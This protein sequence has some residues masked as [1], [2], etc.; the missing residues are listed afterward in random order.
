MSPFQE[1]A[2]GAEIAVDLKGWTSAG[3]REISV[4]DGDAASRGLLEHR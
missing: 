2:I 3:T 4:P 1:N